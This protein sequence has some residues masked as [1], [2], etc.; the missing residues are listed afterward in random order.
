M[1]ISALTRRKSSLKQDYKIRATHDDKKSNRFTIF[2]ITTL[3]VIA[4]ATIN[5]K[6]YF[7]QP[8]DLPAGVDKQLNNSKPE[9]LQALS[10]NIILEKFPDS[11]LSLPLPEKNTRKLS[12]P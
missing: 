1:E 9:P 2:V 12:S 6:F 7:N 8:S 10:S 4:I 5:N 11:D 3:M